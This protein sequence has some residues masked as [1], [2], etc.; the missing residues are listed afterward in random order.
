MGKHDT[1]RHPQ[2]TTTRQK[3]MVRL[4]ERGRN[5]SLLLPTLRRRELDQRQPTRTQRH[6]RLRTTRMENIQNTVA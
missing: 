3:R 5:R 6:A 2:T 1:H 4:R